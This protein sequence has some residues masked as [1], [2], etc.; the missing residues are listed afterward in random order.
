METTQ[1]PKVGVCT[2]RVTQDLPL[3]CHRLSPAECFRTFVKAVFYVGKGT[4]A[5]PYCH[6]SEALS[7]YRAGT[8]KV[9]WA[10]DCPGEGGSRPRWWARGRG[11]GAAVPPQGCPKVR[12]ILEIWGS[13]QGVISV[14]CFQSSVPAEAYTRESC[15]VEALGEWGCGGGTGPGIGSATSPTPLRAEQGAAACPGV[16]GEFGV[17]GWQ[18]GVWAQAPHSPSPVGERCLGEGA[19]G[20]P[21]GLRVL[22]GRNEGAEPIRGG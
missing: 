13:G 7:Q 6:L 2:P 1:A 18:H 14:H 16:H 3:R 9:G 11:D 12:R 5:R 10:G 20:D 17:R 21:T 4:R 15:V 8:R 19:N 22:T